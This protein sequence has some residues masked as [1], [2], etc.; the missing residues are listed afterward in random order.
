MREPE[1]PF[2]R[3]M[4][5]PILFFA[6]LMCSSLSWA[7]ALKNVTAICRIQFQ[8]KVT[9]HFRNRITKIWSVRTKIA[10]IVKIFRKKKFAAT[11][12]LFTV[13]VNLPT[14]KIWGQSDKL[15]MSLSFLQCPPQV[16][17]LIRE[18]SAK[19]VNQTGNFY[20]RPKLKTAISLPTF[21]IFENFF[22]WKLVHA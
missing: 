9:E 12:L 13:R 7:K 8:W 11:F 14:V 18:N 10:L 15:P 2:E 16:K 19:Y 22:R 6:Y 20:F 3:Y 21:N 5:K 4:S 17:K 1:S